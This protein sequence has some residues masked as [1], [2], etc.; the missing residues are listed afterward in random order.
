MDSVIQQIIVVMNPTQQKAILRS[1]LAMR[2]SRFCQLS[3]SE[4]NVL[5]VKADMDSAIALSLRSRDDEYFGMIPPKD[6]DPFEEPP[7]LIRIDTMDHS[8]RNSL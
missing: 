1:N 4:E 3:F 6:A 7:D 8:G 5:E 2:L